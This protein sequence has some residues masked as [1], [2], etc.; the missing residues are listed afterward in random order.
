MIFFNPFFF[1][2]LLLEISLSLAS[3][4]LELAVA[5][6]LEEAAGCWISLIWA[7]AGAGTSFA[8]AL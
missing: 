2:F 6:L 7:G 1:F 4:E 5:P 8:M 3:V